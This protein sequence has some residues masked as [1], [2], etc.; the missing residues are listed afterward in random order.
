V[1]PYP[2]ASDEELVLRTLLGDRAAYDELV[3]RF[4]PGVVLVAEQVLGS[5]FAAEDVAQDALL[6]AY[7]ALPTLAEPAKFAP[8][9]RAIARHRALRVAISQ[10]RAATA[11]PELLERSPLVADSDLDPYEEAAR[12]A[13]RM[14]VRAMV[15]ELPPEFATVLILHY[16][17][18]WP[19]ARIT[20]FLSLPIATVK[21]RMYRGR[22]LLFCRLTQVHV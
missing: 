12:R 11:D 6:Q 19:L 16:W 21:W 15:G 14:T 20:E 8:W 13:D 1:N 5:R 22:R 18:Q 7:R 4:R 3:R 10:R 9:L 17:E 2:I